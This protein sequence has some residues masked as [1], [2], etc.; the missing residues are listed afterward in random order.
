MSAPLSAQTELF[1]K[2][3]AEQANSGAWNMALDEAL[4]NA[5]VHQELCALRLYQ[6]SEPT[7]SLGHFQKLD[8]PVV[9]QRF[10]LL[11]KVKRL[12]GG[13]AILHDVEL[14]Y[15][16]VLPASHPLCRQPGE[17]YDRVHEQIVAVLNDWGVPCA[18]RGTPLSGPEPFL[19]FGRGDPRD[20]V[21]QG[22][23]LVGSAQRRR[24]GAV[25]QHGAILLGASGHAPEF[26]GILEL[27][28]Q[29]FNRDELSQQLALRIAPAL[30]TPVFL[31]NWPTETLQAAGM[32]LSAY[33]HV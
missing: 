31:S 30:G 4:L 25:L 23:K 9:A 10:P 3:V 19:C 20:I 1:C 26:P 8:D 29:A 22:H 5:A 16:C 33:Q 7:V 12:S 21:Y 17:I 11:A 13:G 14:T 28:G 18:M 6:W 27:T 32:L 24:S 2:T 15:S